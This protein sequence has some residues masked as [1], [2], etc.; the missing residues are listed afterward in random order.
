[1]KK[2]RCRTEK[3]GSVEQGDLQTHKDQELNRT[4][5]RPSHTKDSACLLPALA[6]LSSGVLHSGMAGERIVS[7]SCGVLSSKTVLNSPL[8]HRLFLWGRVLKKSEAQTWVTLFEGSSRQEPGP[9]PLRACVRGYAGI[10]ICN[11]EEVRCTC[12][13]KCHFVNI[14][15]LTQTPTVVTSQG[16]IRLRDQSEIHIGQSP[17]SS[18]DMAR[19]SPVH[20]EGCGPQGGQSPFHY[21]EPFPH[22]QQ[23]SVWEPRS[24]VN[25]LVLS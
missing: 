11:S 20:T 18:C 5:S 16:N 19:G 15:V 8:R 2:L 9:P 23:P 3:C 7:W 25:K 24:L 12:T 6:T 17:L 13:T 10:V 4:K 22:L 14:N 1:M 21:G